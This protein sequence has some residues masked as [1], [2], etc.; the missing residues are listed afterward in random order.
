VFG[1]VFRGATAYPRAKGVWRDDERD[2]TLV[3]DE[4]VVLHCD[5]TIHAGR[6][7]T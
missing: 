6:R 1:R 5:T 3:K 7:F 2:G 4:P